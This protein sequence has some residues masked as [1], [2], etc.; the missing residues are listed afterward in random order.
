MHELNEAR[1]LS[2]RI[3][4]TDEC[5]FTSSV[6]MPRAF[7]K[8]RRNIRVKRSL[9][10]VATVY[11][12]AGI[13]LEFGVEGFRVYR[14]PVNGAM[15]GELLEDINKQGKSYVVFGDNASIHT[16]STMSEIYNKN[17]TWFIGS[18]QY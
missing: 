15:F 11:L 2:R 14:K 9:T 13:S 18:V 16:S 8:T 17:K 4:F 1:G 10:E 3:V 12:L 6:V 7:S 5:L